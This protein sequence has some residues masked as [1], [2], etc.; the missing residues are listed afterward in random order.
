MTVLNS[1]YKAN[2][3]KDMPCFS[4]QS[5]APWH[6]RLKEAVERLLE[7]EKKQE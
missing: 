5:K 1:I 2:N 4:W 3:G 6:V 7:K